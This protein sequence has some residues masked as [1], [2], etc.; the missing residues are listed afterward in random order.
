MRQWLLFVSVLFAASIGYFGW[1]NSEGSSNEIFSQARAVPPEAA[2]LCPWRNPESDLKQFFPEADRHTLETRILSGVR[3]ELAE[4]L[5][6][7][8]TG[9]ENALRLGRVYR[10]SQCLGT[11][12]TRRVKGEFGAIE[13]VLATDDGPTVRGLRLQRLREPAPVE[14]ALEDPK[15]LNSFVGK[16]PGDP[17]KLGVDVPE[18]TNEAKQSAEAIVQGARALLILLSTSSEAQTPPLA[19]GHH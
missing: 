3:T 14:N 6:R 5:G 1:R 10:G 13:L 12:L 17:W 15:W 18:V 19:T 7:Q 8:P 4:K 16:R 11:V 2:P 9:D